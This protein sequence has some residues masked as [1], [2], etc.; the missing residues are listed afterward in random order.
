VGASKNATGFMLQLPFTKQNYQNSLFEVT[1]RQNF[2]QLLP[3]RTSEILS[4]THQYAVTS[5]VSVNKVNVNES[6][7]SHKLTKSESNQETSQYYFKKERQSDIFF[8][9]GVDP[10]C[11]HE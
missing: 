9:K 10:Y 7:W 11:S 5:V 8:E 3:K 1:F 4:G 2:V 6:N